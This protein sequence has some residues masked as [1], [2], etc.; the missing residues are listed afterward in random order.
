MLILDHSEV[1]FGQ[2][3][4]F[5]E[6]RPENPCNSPKPERASE[7]LFWT[8]RKHHSGSCLTSRKSGS[9]LPS[10]LCVFTASR[11]PCMHASC[12][13]TDECCQCASG[14]AQTTF[15]RAQELHQGHPNH[16]LNSFLK[17]FEECSVSLGFPNFLLCWLA[18]H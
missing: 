1:P 10:L 9:Y 18:K 2:L 7:C 5:N 12:R 13:C 11:S 17:V 15:D 4:H 14:R 6:I 8:V 16:T 3:P